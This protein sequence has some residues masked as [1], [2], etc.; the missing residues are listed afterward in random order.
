MN[1]TSL[2]TLPT[3]ITQDEII[4]YCQR[5]KIAELAVF[6]SA[7]RDDFKLSSDIDILVT[8]EADARWTLLDH[9]QMQDELGIL[10]GRK[11]DLV[12][13]RGLENSRNRIRREA[14]LNS[15]EVVYVSA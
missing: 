5:Y 11:I 1:E 8:F 2:K 3:Q 4:D 13:K 15:A 7:L 10:L 6:G 9:V 14:I 12:S